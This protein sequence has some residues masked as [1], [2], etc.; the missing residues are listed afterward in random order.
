MSLFFESK[1][2]I[3]KTRP[4]NSPRLSARSGFLARTGFATSLIGSLFATSAHTQTKPK[5]MPKPKATNSQTLAP[6][7]SATISAD[8]VFSKILKE[9]QGE[10]DASK[11]IYLISKELE[12]PKYKNNELR[13]DMLLKVLNSPF[14]NDNYVQSLMVSEIKKFNNLGTNFYKVFDRFL[15]VVDLDGILMASHLE[16]IFRYIL[17]NGKVGEKGEEVNMF[18]NGYKDIYDFDSLLLKL[19]KNPKIDM[20]KMMSFFLMKVL[21]T[22]KVDGKDL[23]EFGSSLKESLSPDLLGLSKFKSIGEAI[24]SDKFTG[25]FPVTLEHFSKILF[26]LYPDQVE[27]KIAVLDKKWSSLKELL[28]SKEYLSLGKDKYE[29]LLFLFTYLDI[30]N[31]SFKNLR[32]KNLS[33]HSMKSLVTRDLFINNFN[34]DFHFESTFLREYILRKELIFILFALRDKMNMSTFA[35]LKNN[36]E[37]LLKFTNPYI[38]DGMFLEIYAKYY[39][40]TNPEEREAAMFFKKFTSPYVDLVMRSQS[41]AAVNNIG[42][43]F[44]WSGGIKSDTALEKLIPVYELILQLVE[45]KNLTSR[46]KAEIAAR[47]TRNLFFKNAEISIE[48]IRKVILEINLERDKY[49][50]IEIYGGKSILVANNEK[51][52][53]RAPRFGPQALQNSIKRV[54]KDF[55]FI[56]QDQQYSDNSYVPNKLKSE[57]VNTDGKLTVHF[58][59]HGY[60]K[61]E[62]EGKD[63]Y[64]IV[65]T[66]DYA[67]LPGNPQESLSIEMSD[68][69]QMFVDRYKNPINRLNALK[70]Q[71]TVILSNCYGETVRAFADQYILKMKN[72]GFKDGEIPIIFGITET[73][74][75]QLGFSNYTTPHNTLFPEVVMGLSPDSKNTHKPIMGDVIKN[76]NLYNESN[77]TLY[78]IGPKQMQLSESVFGVD[79]KFG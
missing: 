65:A 13:T 55:V 54:S 29:R 4:K 50:N 39:N 11:F 59:G 12:L 64:K 24:D 33:S 75:G 48:N 77:P 78:I 47:V 16:E 46:E 57:I 63:K 36:L 42:S 67:K 58:D 37:Y 43:S 23:Y 9:V 60:A 14:V 20:Q 35:L 28:E 6:E 8:Q 27:S 25:G 15:E 76:D 71:D 10:K 79:I 69:A 34:N 53:T 51:L 72:A 38:Y 41:F 74:F 68:L 32:F 70:I 52:S 3:K 21:I 66:F 19:A 49:S 44:A 18:S 56:N 61:K 45:Y 73:E 30:D 2:K 26:R 5:I 7:R 40:S 62:S 31:Y 17:L 22:P 1:R